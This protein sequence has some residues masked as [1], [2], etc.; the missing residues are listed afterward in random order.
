MRR[1]PF[2]FVAL[3]L[4]AL[5][6]AACG[7]GGGGGADQVGAGAAVYEAEC[8]ECHDQGVGPALDAATLQG[9]FANAQEL[10][11]YTAQNMPLDAP[12]SLTDEQYWNVTA[13][14]VD[15]IG[16]LPDDTTLDANT[17]AG[18]PLQ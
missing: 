5:M 10:H 14:L 17:A 12:G 9:S 8:A 16:A 4:V 13:Y 1:F 6:L 3:V 7:G 18:V 2:V 15:D 11:D